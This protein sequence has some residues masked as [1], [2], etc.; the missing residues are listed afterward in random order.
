MMG[1]K[2]AVPKIKNMLN[3]HR[4]ITRLPVSQ[5]QIRQAITDLQ[6][7]LSEQGIDH[8]DLIESITGNNTVAS[9]ARRALKL[10]DTRNQN[11][12]ASQPLTTNQY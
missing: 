3:D 7:K 10:I 2:N 5:R 6:P 12:P 4:P 9:T 8:K 11:I 1:A